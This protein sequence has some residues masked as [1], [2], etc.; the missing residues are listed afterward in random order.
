MKTFTRNKALRFGGHRNGEVDP[1]QRAVH[2]RCQHGRCKWLR[3]KVR[4]ATT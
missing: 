2:D 1:I 3:R 4:D